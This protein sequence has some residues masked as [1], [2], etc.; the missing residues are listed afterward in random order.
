MPATR[1][2]NLGILE[3]GIQPRSLSAFWATVSG[4][5]DTLAPWQARLFLQHIFTTGAIPG[6]APGEKSVSE[7][8]IKGTG[9]KGLRGF[10]Y[11]EIIGKLTGIAS[12]TVET[13]WQGKAQ[14]E[15]WS[16]DVQD[17]QGNVAPAGW[18]GITSMMYARQKLGIS[19]N[20]FGSPAGFAKAVLSGNPLYG[21]KFGA[22]VKAGNIPM[23]ALSQKD[24]SQISSA[25]TK[26]MG[27]WGIESLE[28]FD[29]AAPMIANNLLR[30]SMEIR[31][32]FEKER[33]RGGPGML[34][35]GLM[36]LAGPLT[37]MAVGGTM[38]AGGAEI[39]KAA[40][41]EHSLLYGLGD[42][43]QSFGGKMFEGGAGYAPKY[44]GMGLDPQRYD[45]T[46]IQKYEGPRTQAGRA[47]GG[48]GDLLFEQPLP[49]YDPEEERRK[50]EERRRLEELMTP[51]RWDE[52]PWR[53]KSSPYWGQSYWGQQ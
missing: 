39:A 40:G 36:R 8:L 1:F 50:E 12:G 3:R 35:R 34:E 33:K 47:A 23:S 11:K 49:L 20:P 32:K 53:F 6:G 24:P 37:K 26:L 42:V 29:A 7:K 44:S 15:G 25:T 4:S 46:N 27:D 2:Q 30:N 43:M 5:L 51:Y 48:I 52:K 22:A 19:S 14:K 31:R 18:K 16:Q 38:F 13:R 21:G 9:G 17:P 41:P 28:G 10:S 45:P